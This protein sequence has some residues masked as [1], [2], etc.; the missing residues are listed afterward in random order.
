MHQQL[1]DRVV[2]GQQHTQPGK[3]PPGLRHLAQLR[4]CAVWPRVRGR[5]AHGQRHGET[6]AL[7][8]LAHQFDAAAHQ[9]DQL[10]TDGQ[11][12]PA[13]PVTA[14]GGGVGLGERVKN[15]GLVLAGN[16]H[17]AVLHL[18][19]QALRRS[20]AGGEHARGDRDAPAARRE[21]Q[22]VGQQVAQHLAQPP[23]V[24]LHALGQIGCQ[25]QAPAQRFGMR[26]LAVKRTHFLQGVAQQEVHVFHGQLA[27]F[28]ARKV[29]HIV[30]QVQQGV[31]RLVHQVEPA[32][33]FGVERGVDQQARQTDQGVERG[34]HLMA[35]VGQEL[36]LGPAGLL[37]QLA[38][39]HARFFH[40]LALAN[41]RV[42]AHEAQ[43]PPRGVLLR[44]H[45][46]ALD[47]EPSAGSA[48]AVLHHAA[49]PPPGA[50]VARR[51]LHQS[52]VVRVHELKQGGG[53]PVAVHGH[54]AQHLAPAR[55]QVHLGRTELPIPQGQAGR[56]H[57]Q[58]QAVLGG[59][60]R[61][62]GQ[63]TAV[64]LPVH[65]AA[66]LVQLVVLAF[67]LGQ[68]LLGALALSEQLLACALQILS[69]ALGRRG[70]E[71]RAACGPGTKGVSCRRAPPSAPE[72]AATPF[73]YRHAGRQVER[74]VRGPWQ[75]V[76]R[77]RARGRCRPARLRARRCVRAALRIRAA[78]CSSASV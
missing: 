21:L 52:A 5:F 74:R 57:G 50:Q 29:Q 24:A 20:R 31:G 68:Q 30:E 75:K 65:R 73:R 55:G 41:V 13:A 6:A 2:L 12:E 23:R 40:P 62:F 11:T 38:G 22:R 47:P 78:P 15:A 63:Q 14:R 60:Q 8:Q 19:S 39:A 72:P 58:L 49:L 1:V 10:R 42:C 33:L 4:R 25:Q 69:D 32:C 71:R 66:Q 35:D 64:G 26:L 53:V 56:V 16:A 18:Q 37:G 9:L 67:H 17:A 3:T 36:A 61:L 27:R 59:V 48:H 54:L 45:A 34:A 46:M 28:D 7:A 70:H 44:D 76:D 77:R 51:G 43:R